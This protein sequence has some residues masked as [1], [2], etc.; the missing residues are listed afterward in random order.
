[1]VLESDIFIKL[2]INKNQVRKVLLHV[3]D[4]RE[5]GVVPVKFAFM[6]GGGYQL[7]FLLWGGGGTE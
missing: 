6:G 1:M 4:Y 2:H 5:R 7:T 3:H